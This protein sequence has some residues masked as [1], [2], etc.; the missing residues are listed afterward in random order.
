MFGFVNKK[1]HEVLKKRIQALE[2]DKS[3]LSTLITNWQTSPDALP[4]KNNYTTYTS[5][6]ST[7][8]KMYNSETTYGSETLRGIIDTRT[9]FI[10]GEGAS[11]VANRKKTQ[12]F[13][14][15]FMKFNYL[16][17]STLLEMI[18]TSEMEGKMLTTFDVAE[19]MGKRQVKIDPHVW[20]T[21]NYKVETK[22]NNKNYITKITFTNKDGSTEDVKSE[23]AYMKIG[24]TMDKVNDTTTRTGCILTQIEN[25]SRCLYDLRKNNHLFAKIMLWVKTNTGEEAKSINNDLVGG[26]FGIG[27][28]Y[29]GTGDGKFIAPPL[30]A[31]EALSGEMLL[32]IKIIST[33]TGIPIHWLA[34]TEMLSNR[35]TAET[36]LEVINAATIKERTIWEEYL[37]EIIVKA[38]EIGVDAGIDGAVLDYDFQV[39]L[40][41]ISYATLKQIQETWMPLQAADVIS[42][43]TLRNRVPHINPAE[44]K[45]LIEKEKKENME[46]APIDFRADITT[47][48]SEEDDDSGADGAEQTG[49]D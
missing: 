49:A 40:P 32:N 3:L 30:G 17:G 29:A 33:V 1:Q 47:E 18:Q 45:K 43:A 11:V 42:M 24:G 25:Y 26:Q 22:E 41:L 28:S 15:D 9:A 39:T 19:K 14:D 48:T 34:W 6:V 16:Y 21:R 5:Q 23:Y 8:Y 46:R 35:A 7:I 12:T 44:E 10:G 36:L 4:T 20:Y 38:M 13:I 37:Y 2:A 31:H 27:K